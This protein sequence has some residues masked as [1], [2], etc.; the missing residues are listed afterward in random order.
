MPLLGRSRFRCSR[1]WNTLLWYVRIFVRKFGADGG[2][3]PAPVEN[4]TIASQIVSFLANMLYGS[5]ATCCGKIRANIRP[6]SRK[7]S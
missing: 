7:Y 1:I 4:C 2:R 5:M 3:L 6:G